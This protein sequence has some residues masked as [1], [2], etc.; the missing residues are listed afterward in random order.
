[1]EYRREAT[2]SAGF[3]QQL[4]VG[5][6]ARGYYYYVQGKV[7]VG[8]DP[9]AVDEKLIAKYGV[10]ASKG[11]RFRRKALGYANVQ[12]IRYKRDFVLVATEGY[13]ESLHLEASNLRDARL[14]PIRIFGYAI[15]YRNGRV[16]VRIEKRLY[17]QI[18]AR[19][20]EL[21]VHRKRDWIENALS[22]LRFE[23]YAPVRSQLHCIL[24]A[25]NK[26]RAKAQF[27]PVRAS[28]IRTM[29]RIVLPFDRHECCQTR[30]SARLALL[31][32]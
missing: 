20:T 10:T 3:V 29:R 2:S 4:A 9:R 17:L 13:H 25:V 24:R 1:M 26:R 14:M 21:A 27:E 32:R 8:K 31:G 23:P 16:S 11:A 28:C 6:L 22:S 18:K 19:M 30:V 15:S 5:Y 12:Y 7:P